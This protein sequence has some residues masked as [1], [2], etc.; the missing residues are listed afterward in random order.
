MSQHAAPL[1]PGT[2]LD[3]RFEIREVLGAGAFGVV[4]RATQMVFGHPLREVAIKLFRVDAVDPARVREIFADAITLVGMQEEAASPEVSRRI[5]QV[6]DIGVLG[7]ESQPFISMRLVPGKRTLE[8]PVKE[9]GKG[10]PLNL[11]L[12][13]FRELLVPLAWMHTLNPKV[14]HADLKPD[15][16]LLAQDNSLIVTDFGLA[17]R[18]PVKSFGGAIQYQA[19]ETLLGNGADES[20]DVYALGIILYQLL[21]GRHPF[22]GVALEA[23]AADDEQGRIRAHIEARKWEMR[24]EDPTVSRDRE[25]IVPPTEL[26][27]ELI[28]HPQIE[29]MVAKCLAYGQ[30]HRYH[31]ARQLLD[32]LDRYEDTGVTGAGKVVPTARAIPRKEKSGAARIADG[33]AL[34][35]TGR[36]DEAIKR[37]KVLLSKEPKHQQALLLLAEMLV[38][39][40]DLEG[41]Q[42][43]CR[44]AQRIDPTNPAVL[45][46]WALVFDAQGKRQLADTMRRRA[47]KARL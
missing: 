25:R 41:G 37:V 24:S 26:N 31:N 40:G 21:T 6:Y 35:Q 22:S 11:A 17:S 20:A 42:A 32:E 36:I 16:I 7:P 19:P 28:D 12:Y 45:D 39:Q 29:A 9:Y 2:V 47:M 43:A 34:F 8:E 30:S 15:N 27:K 46:T 33:M 4:Y 38:K 14:V 18:L 13:Y 1:A 5:V 3:D 23:D 10:M 44:D